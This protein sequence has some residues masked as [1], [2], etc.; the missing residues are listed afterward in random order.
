ML[1]SQPIVRSYHYFTVHCP[2]PLKGFMRKALKGSLHLFIPEDT[3]NDIPWLHNGRSAQ[4]QIKTRD[5]AK[6]LFW[7][8]AA[9]LS[10]LVIGQL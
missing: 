8:V 3:S 10:A 7:I 4:S 5:L 9:I 2:P 6:S 1:E